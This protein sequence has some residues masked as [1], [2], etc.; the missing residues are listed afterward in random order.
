MTDLIDISIELARSHLRELYACDAELQYTSTVHIV[1]GSSIL[2]GRVHLFEISGH[3]LAVRASVWASRPK[4]GGET[5]MHVVLH[6]KGIGTVADAV[7]S[8]HSKL[9]G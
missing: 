1:Q 8:V 7:R 5:T 3:A 4:R 2:A 9:L 6:T